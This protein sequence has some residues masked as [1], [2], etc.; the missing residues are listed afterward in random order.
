MGKWSLILVVLSLPLSLLTESY[1]IITRSHNLR[2]NLFFTFSKCQNYHVTSQKDSKYVSGLL[3]RGLHRLG[4]HTWAWWNWSCSFPSYFCYSGLFGFSLVQQNGLV[5][6]LPTSFRIFD[7]FCQ[8]QVLKK[9]SQDDKN[10]CFRWILV[11]IGL[12]NTRRYKINGILMTASFF[13]CRICTCPI[14]WFYVWKVWNTEA[15]SR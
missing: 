14:Y 7:A 6:L 8:F 15:F 4:P 2:G 9:S 5:F 12:K 3:S 11:S 1:S 13:L 10:W